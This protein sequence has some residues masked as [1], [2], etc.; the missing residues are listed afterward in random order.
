MSKSKYFTGQPIY[1]QLLSYLPQRKVKDIAD[2]HNADR[3][4]KNFRTYTHLVTMLY[5]IFNRC[6]GIRE[7]T[8]GLLAW[9]G[10]IQHL[11]INYFPRRSTIS[12][13]NTSRP[14]EV[15]EDIYYWL[16]DRY[17]HFLPDSRSKIASRLYIVDSTTI[18]LFQEVLKNAGRNPADG[19][20]KGGIKVHTLMR[21]DQD[22]PCLI[23]FS[24]GAGA[25]SPF[26]QNIHLQR[27]S[28]VVFDRGYNDYKQY[29][30][31][32]E[33]NVT[34]VTRLRSNTVIK[35]LREKKISDKEKQNG[36]LLDQIIE[37]GHTKHN[38]TTRVKARLI[39][40]EDKKSKRIFEF[41]TNNNQFK[42]STIALF[43]KN[44]WQIESLFKRIKQNYPLQSFLGES[45][46][47]IK[48]Q[49]WC[50]LIADLILKI[51]KAKAGKNWSFS[52]LAAM[53][54][55]HLMTYIN[56]FDFLINPEKSLIRNQIK[57]FQLPLFPT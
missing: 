8:S 1:S 25:D 32:S 29:N 13:A 38:N 18:Q 44:R 53:V 3:Y 26:L 30:R 19:K 43:Y 57:S 48:I 55:L 12:D 28:I 22:V 10:R 39:K 45:E 11:G 27:G 35:V 42:P 15:F 40:Y 52:N 17:K 51:V 4:Y 47:A 14:A 41:I 21:S 36:I 56:L 20:R 9:E 23:R 49:I 50:A 54:R 24:A 6:T 7:V 34:W 31:F 16:Y 2:E 33:E 37:M 46:N 5:A